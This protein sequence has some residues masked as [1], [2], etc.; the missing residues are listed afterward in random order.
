MSFFLKF[1]PPRIAAL[2]L[3]LATL[4]HYLAP[5]AAIKIHQSYL[6]GSVLL[7]GGFGIMTWAWHLF[8]LNRLI[9]CP[10]APAADVLLTRGPYRLTRNP[11]YL[12]MVFLMLGI[13]LMAGTLP[14]FIVTAAF[15]FII[16]NAF[17]PYEERK[18]ADSIG[19]AYI[20]YKKRVR[21]WL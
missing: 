14:F 6:V 7:F 1:R 3:I 13:A 9:L 10:T 8:K 20:E 16:N 17:C 11:M 12:G 2:L 15:F 19:G 18:M 21:R 5:A 4:A